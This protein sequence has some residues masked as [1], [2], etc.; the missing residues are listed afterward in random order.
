MMKPAGQEAA[1]GCGCASAT[2][3]LCGLAI[4]DHSHAVQPDAHRPGSQSPEQLGR[5]V[6]ATA[7]ATPLPPPRCSLT[8]LCTAL[9]DAHGCVGSVHCACMVRAASPSPATVSSTVAGAVSFGAAFPGLLG[10]A[11]SLGLFDFHAAAVPPSGSHVTYPEAAA[12]QLR[13]RHS[14]RAACCCCCCCASPSPTA[15][16]LAGCMDV[17]GE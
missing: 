4:L 10:S 3:S 1:C 14:H 13:L 15:A 12:E 5:H 2:T 11:P 17:A 9:A 6:D 7:C 16:S 8:R